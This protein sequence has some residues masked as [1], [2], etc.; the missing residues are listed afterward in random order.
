[1]GKTDA[2]PSFADLIQEAQKTPQSTS[3]GVDVSSPFPTP[4]P[5][6]HVLR[7]LDEEEDPLKAPGVPKYNYEAHVQY[8]E[9]PSDNTAYENTLNEILNGNAIL[10]YEERHFTKEGDC[11]IVVNYLTYKPPP[12]EKDDDEE[13][14][15][16][17][18]RGN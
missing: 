10:R 16:H 12:K 4:I 8:Y 13:E 14:E 2:P 5:D 9:L 18:K 7:N 6:D 17:R 3:M 15:E 11:I 1:M